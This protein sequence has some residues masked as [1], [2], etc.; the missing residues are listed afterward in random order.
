MPTSPAILAGNPAAPGSGDFACEVTAQRGEVR[1]GR[2][3][4]GAF[5]SDFPV[6][7]WELQAREA[8]PDFRVEEGELLD[9]EIDELRLMFTRPM[10]DPVGD[11]DPNDVTNPANYRWLTPG[12][13]AIFDTVTCGPIQGDD[14]AVTIDSVI[15]GGTVAVLGIN[16]GATLP[17]A[18]YRFSVCGSSSLF[19]LDGT[20]LDGDSDGIAGGD[21]V[22]NFSVLKRQNGPLYTVNTTLDEDDGYCS[23][24]HCSLREAVGAANSASG[25]TISL[26][27]GTYM[28]TVPG[29]GGQPLSASLDFMAPI[30]LVGV[31]PE[32]TIID[33]TLLNDRLIA[34]HLQASSI[35]NL[36]IQNGTATLTRVGTGGAICNTGNLIQSNIIVRSNTA[37]ADG[38]GIYNSGNLTVTDS[39]LE[40]NTASSSGGAIANYGVLRFQF[41]TMRNN[42]AGSNGGG[43]YSTQNSLNITSSTIEGNTA[44]SGAGIFPASGTATLVNSTV[45]GNAALN[46][47]GGIGIIQG[48]SA[49]A[50]THVELTH[51][52]LANN[53]A[54]SDDD[55]E[56]DGGGI[57]ASYAEVF[58]IGNTLLAQNADLGGEAADCGAIVAESIDSLGHNLIGDATG[59]SFAGDTSGDIIG[60]DPVL[61]PLQDNGGPTYTHALLSGSPSISGRQPLRA[62]GST[63]CGAP[64]RGCLRYTCL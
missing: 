25:G 15:Y 58:H 31:G 3:D 19:D 35:A 1:A 64:T 4:I 24:A 63:G 42:S 53:V 14:S 2:C 17:D 36:T 33:G 40:D 60:V 55:G 10:L 48:S 51:V 39:L 5:E 54:D 57:F 47:G 61:S 13:N 41:S 16:G 38:G 11:S 49:A 30:Q 18:S 22:V 52:T 6:T 50:F 20:L 28:L 23:I 9:G 12:P 27:A 56:G 8:V 21:Y 62:G 26:P 32:Q 7:V 37:F 59:C 43:I 29:V 46:H 44:G 45:S 34:N